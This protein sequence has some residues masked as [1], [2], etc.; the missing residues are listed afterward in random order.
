VYRKQR[1]DDKILS[2]MFYFVINYDFF[3]H[4]FDLFLLKLSFLHHLLKI[5]VQKR[6]CSFVC[7][8]EVRNGRPKVEMPSSE[9]V[10]VILFAQKFWEK[11]NRTHFMRNN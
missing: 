11:P 1:P 3:N 2:F 7:L 8:R 5:C 9:F 6:C 10:L 4:V